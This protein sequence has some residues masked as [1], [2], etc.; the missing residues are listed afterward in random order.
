[1]AT[2]LPQDARLVDISAHY[3]ETSIPR[4]LKQSQPLPD[5][6]WGKLIVEEGEILLV[7]K[8]SSGGEKLAAESETIIPP[9]TPFRIAPTGAEAR[10]YFQYYHPAILDDPEELV[11]SLGR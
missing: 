3:N 8:G 2:E 7:V 4:E 1:M 6:L 10:F 5:G 9:E 11:G